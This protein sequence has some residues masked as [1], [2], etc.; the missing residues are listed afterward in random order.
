MSRRVVVLL[1]GGWVAVS[2]IAYSRGCATCPCRK[3]PLSLLSASSTAA[4]VGTFTGERLLT[5]PQGEYRVL[6]FQVLEVL[7]GD[8]P[9][10]VDV[11]TG[12]GSGRCGINL[13]LG[14]TAGV[15]AYPV[16]PGLVTEACSI[17]SPDKL[18]SVMR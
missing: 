17:V 2:A 4:F 8:V 9:A 5:L 13:D 14:E 1:V 3:T 16:P 11:R 10:V 15:A 6:S 7:R 12:S 18:R